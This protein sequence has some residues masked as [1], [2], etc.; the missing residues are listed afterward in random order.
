MN[1]INLSSNYIAFILLFLGGIC[2]V[3]S[4]GNLDIENN[5]DKVNAIFD[6]A[7]NLEIGNP[8]S[9]IY[10]YKHAAEISQSIDYQLGYGRA[11]LY[12]GIVLSDQGKYDEAINYYL[13]SIDI[14]KQIPYPAGVASSFVNIGN[15]YQ[16]QAEYSKSIQNY[17]EGIKL[18]EEI[19]D[20]A[21]LLYAYTNIGGIFS[22]VE[23]FE[24]SRYYYEKSLVFSRKLNDKLNICDC[25][26]NIG[27]L[28]FKQD[29]F[30]ASI[31]F[32]NQA[33][34]IANEINEPYEF[35]LIYNSLS[36]IDTKLSKHEDAFIKSKL[37][38]SYATVLGNPALLSTAQTRLGMNFT[39]LNQID[40]ADYYI[41][42]GI[43]LA[44]QG[45]NNEVLITAYY[46]MAELQ[47][48]KGNYKS[49]N[50]W[51]KKHYILQDSASGQKQQHIVSGL[52]IEYET[53][54]KDLELSEKALEIERNEALLSKR[55]YFI[56]ALSGALISAFVFLFLIR[57]SLKQ[58]KILAETNVAL[59]KEKIIQLKNEQQV[60]ALKS[61]M[62]GE[63]KERSR[64]AK[65]LHD[66]LGG[67]LSS[68]KLFFSN[69]Q[70][71]NE[72]LKK[73]AD[74]NKA[75][76]LLD[77]TSLEARK[78]AHNLM[79]EALVKFGLIDALKDFCN[80]ISSSNSLT[81]DFQSYHLTERLPETMEIMIYRIAQELVN[82]IVKHAKA[83]E[84]IVQLMQNDNVLYLTVE[85]NGIGF[86]K[87]K[88]NKT[89]AGMSNIKS[90]IDYL[91]GSFE[92]DSAI[93]KGTSINI[94]IL[95][96]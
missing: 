35:Y 34:K 48:I 51:L 72:G 9:A 11:M 7:Y 18:F 73:S 80:N 68:V 28:E 53:E 92:I 3:H 22:D 36:D 13:Q 44:R 40:S 59:E 8:D 25:L 88:I 14:F 55:N 95:L 70:T 47:E 27:I 91:N 19:Q 17:L 90:R 69:I 37:C 42:N 24:K 30:Q 15:I 50:E 29:H 38:L 32:L 16:L 10:L 56:F 12:Q 87:E 86:D 62:D 78:I 54:K 89:S 6:V 4:Q 41:N 33:L 5:A 21:R 43:R 93:N 84:A 67:L 66:G 71:E 77:N 75:L 65:D 94:N 45:Q 63:E 64:I 58:K 85:D 96:S 23:Q 26:I 46:W 20:T 60:V 81:I 79:P 1:L 49:A 74:F 39:K 82:N 83:T 31:S 57:R 52:E 61:M 76:E 2:T